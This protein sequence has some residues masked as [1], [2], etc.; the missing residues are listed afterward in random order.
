[1]SKPIYETRPAPVGVGVHA[2]GLFRALVAL[3]GEVRDWQ[4][5]VCGERPS[6]DSICA[7]ADMVIG[8]AIHGRAAP[9]PVA[10]DWDDEESLTAEWAEVCAAWGIPHEDAEEVLMG[11]LS[12]GARLYVSGFV[13]RWQAMR[14]REDAE[15]KAEAADWFGIAR[16]VATPPKAEG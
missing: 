1:M 12:E 10:N 13:L 7:I 14:E 3:R 11:D 9:L 16:D 8:Q 6:L 4:A 15:A 5:A 2:Q